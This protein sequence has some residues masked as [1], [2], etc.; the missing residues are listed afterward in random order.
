MYI[1]GYGSLGKEMQTV[2][3]E[4]NKHIGFLGFIDDSTKKKGKWIKVLQKLPKGAKVIFGIANPRIRERLSLI[5]E[6]ESPWYFNSIH[7]SSFREKDL[8]F[9]IGSY[10]ARYCIIGH[11]CIIGDHCIINHYTH[12]GH[13]C[14]IA[15]FVTIHFGVKI[16][17]YVRIGEKTEVGAGAII[18]PGV[19]IGDNCIIGA[20]AVVTK[21]VESGSKVMGNPAKVKK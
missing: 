15:N 3:Q 1:Y 16:A 5:L 21:N 17:G 20:G 4:S 9:G 10:I 18:L 8:I 13:N 11:E 14:E 7:P 12:I 2:I 6:S 19:K